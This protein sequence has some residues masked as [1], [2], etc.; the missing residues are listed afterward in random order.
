MYERIWF[1]NI[2]T[3]TQN[4]NDKTF[5]FSVDDVVK[6]MKM[7]WKIFVALRVFILFKKIVFVLYLCKQKNMKNR[8]T[9]VE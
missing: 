4:F 7:K 2:T 5:F 3:G 6:N 1:L 8:Y 9:F